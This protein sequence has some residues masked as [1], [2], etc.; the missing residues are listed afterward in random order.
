MR[1]RLLLR[2]VPA[3]AVA[4]VLAL[5]PATVAIAAAPVPAAV[6]AAPVAAVPA[7]V[8]DFTFA[9]FDAVYDLG[10]DGDGRSVLETTETLVAVFP[11]FDQ[12]RGIR[13]AIPLEYDGHPVDVQVLSVTDAAGEPRP[14]EAETD[15][16][17]EFLLVTVAGSDYVHGEQTY[18]IT[19]R[20]HNVTLQP[21]D[22]AVDE[23]Y[24]DVNGVGWAQPFATV[25]A[26]LRVD[27]SLE[28]AFT[29]D[30][31]C[32]R[33]GSGSGAPCEALEVGAAPD[34]LLVARADAIGPYENLTIAAAFEP[35]TFVPRDDSFA[36]SPAALTS[37]VSAFVALAMF[38]LA[39]ILRL[40]RWRPARR[41]TIIAQYEPPAG[42]S[43][44]LAADLVD[45][46]SRGVTATILER[47][48]AGEVRILDRGAKAYSVQFTGGPLGDA[49]AQ[50][51]V[52]ALFDDH[53]QVGQE[54]L[55]S[56]KSTSLGQRLLAIRKAVA[57]RSVASG[58]RRSPSLGV[59][60]VIAVVALFAAVLGFIAAVIALEADM[61]G[62]WPAVA[63]FAGLVF[64]IGAGIAVIGVRPLTVEGRRVRDH[65]EGLRL[66]IRLAEA[67]RIRMLQSPGG[68]LR[69][70]VDVVGA[71]SATP[72]VDQAE[73]LRLT[74]RLLPYAALFGLEKEWLREL[75]SLYETAGQQPGWYAGPSGFD[76]AAF[77]IA[78]SSFAT[79]STTSWS[80][81][82]SSSS[83]SGSG[84]GGSSGGGGGG[85]G[86]GGV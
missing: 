6:A 68:A 18:V 25:R 82:A 74:E 85:G 59:R 13:R 43:A 26:E 27:A 10:R 67:D 55:L 70:P 57:G 49:D 30:A 84:G 66:F 69:D 45:Q 72:G 12:N 38:V 3:I 11:E 2:A 46:P 1:I 32:Y 14:Y 60:I 29:G 24:W 44:L 36:S 50:S 54:R 63:L 78:V 31:A 71:A 21:D 61:G 39:L 65:L 7:G 42:V 15:D 28:D 81:S 51:V 64:A 83:S 56:E 75:A 33:G 8:D 23:F 9:S 80:G 41:G 86:G 35:G 16:D 48:V 17:D 53:P 52:R 76:A 20:Q 40:T 22:A 73:M 79:A 47:A 4:S 5:V 19:Y 77:S 34:P 58:L 62:F 37:A